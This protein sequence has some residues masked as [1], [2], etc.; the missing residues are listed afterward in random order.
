MNKGDTVRYADDF[1]K[2][3][4]PQGVPQLS[5]FRWVVTNL[6]QFKRGGAE[7]VE[8]CRVYPPPHRLYASP[9]SLFTVVTD[10]DR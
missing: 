4:D 5:A 1:L 7:F 9:A 10:E 3:I 6:L 2:D 8:V